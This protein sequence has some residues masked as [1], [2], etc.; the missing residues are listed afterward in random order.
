MENNQLPTH[1]KYLMQYEGI[2]SIMQKL[3]NKQNANV[4]CRFDRLRTTHSKRQKPCEYWKSNH[5][6]T[7]LIT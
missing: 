1:A 5:P 7:H 3:R 6:P 4:I 2:Y